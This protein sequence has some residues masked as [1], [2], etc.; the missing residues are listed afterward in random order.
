MNMNKKLGP[1]WVY[2]T[3]CYLRI[4][5]CDKVNGAYAKSAAITGN[6]VKALHEL[7][8]RERDPKLRVEKGALDR[9]RQLILDTAMVSYYQSLAS[10]SSGNNKSHHS[11]HKSQRKGNFNGNG[12][13]SSNAPQ[14]SAVSSSSRGGRA[15]HS[16]SGSGAAPS[17]GDN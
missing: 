9:Q 10:S 8:D 1:A 7:H 11:K 14:R 2:L 17:T 6:P 16:T 13:G 15:S 4:Y 12:P 3:H 5:L